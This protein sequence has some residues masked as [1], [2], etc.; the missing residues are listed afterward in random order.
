MPIESGTDESRKYPR[1][2]IKGEVEFFIDADIVAAETIDISDGGLRIT[3]KEPVKAT[4]RVTEKSG[5]VAEYQA[6]LVWAKSES[7]ENMSF[8]LKFVNEADLGVDFVSF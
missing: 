7:D 6:K 8:G 4:L 2:E 1:R 5:K 3:T